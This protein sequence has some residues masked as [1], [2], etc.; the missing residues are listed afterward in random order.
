MIKF[1]YGLKDIGAI[2]GIDLAK[3]HT[4]ICVYKRD[5]GFVEF[6]PINVKNTEENKELSL[7]IQLKDLF[8]KIKEKYGKNGVIAVIQ[9]RLPSQCGRF[10]TIQTLQALSAS[11]AI[12]HLAVQVTDGVELYDNDGIHTISIKTLFKSPSCPKPQKEDIRKALVEL[13]HLDDTL[14][15]DDISD[16]IAVVHTLLVKRWNQDID[17]RIKE[18]KKEI[19]GLKLAR[20]KEEREVE[21]NRLSQ[22]KI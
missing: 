5:V 16:A 22:S 17:E 2:I 1:N 11:H 19:K 8:Q 9:E 20:A 7:F 3:F 18:L 4:G 10:S 15:T 6:L 13:Y 14:L 21:I 12:L